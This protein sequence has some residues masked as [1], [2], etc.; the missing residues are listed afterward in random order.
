MAPA[1]WR[2]NVEIRDDCDKSVLVQVV[3]WCRQA[4]SNYLSQRRQNLAIWR[5]QAQLL[6]NAISVLQLIT[7]PM[8]D[9]GG[10]RCFYPGHG[11][12][13]TVERLVIGNIKTLMW[14]HCYNKAISVLHM[15][16]SPVIGV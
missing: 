4:E 2:T 6:Q 8:R 15:T 12:E 10:L 5:H 11:I 3:D 14:C 7:S 9:C 1:I 13:Q 16:K